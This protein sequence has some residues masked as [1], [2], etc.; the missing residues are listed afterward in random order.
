MRFPPAR[1]VLK[2]RSGLSLS[3][4]AAAFAAFSSAPALADA[5]GDAVLAQMDA[6]ASEDAAAWTLVLTP[7]AGQATTYAKIEV[8]VVKDKKVPSELK[9]FNAEG[10]HTKTETRTGYSCEGDVCTPGELKMH[11]NIK[12]AW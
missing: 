4:A 10:K 1:S 12:G 7:K 5:A 2:T 8:T 11:D 9:Y 3:V 6:I